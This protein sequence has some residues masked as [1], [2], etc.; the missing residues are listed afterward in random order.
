M[1]FQNLRATLMKAAWTASRNGHEKT[2]ALIAGQR[3]SAPDRDLGEEVQTELLEAARRGDEGQ[4]RKLFGL[5]VAIEDETAT[6]ELRIGDQMP[7]GSIYAGIS[8]TSGKRMFAAAADLPGV[9][10]FNEAIARVRKLEAHGRKDWGLPTQAELKTLFDSRAAIGGFVTASQGSGTA[11][12][13]WSNTA[14]GPSG[15]WVVNFTDGRDGWIFRDT[16]CVSSRAVR[17]E[18]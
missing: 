13:Y 8:P 7:D 11:C 1:E 10:K 17:A 15:V 4:V 6:G 16:I 18:P 9:M 5:E 2:A 14:N 12:W 3:R